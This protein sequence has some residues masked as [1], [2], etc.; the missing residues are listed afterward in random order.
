MRGADEVAGPRQA[1]GVFPGRPEEA[2]E[3]HLR[4]DRQGGVGR[5][6][7]RQD[8]LEELAELPPELLVLAEMDVELVADHERSQPDSI[9][10]VQHP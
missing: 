1:R 8:L 6:D 4:S 3:G 9:D 5:L 7:P 10:L 2:V